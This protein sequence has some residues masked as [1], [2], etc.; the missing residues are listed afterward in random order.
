M[1]ANS[2]QF[3]FLEA[4]LLVSKLRAEVT[5]LAVFVGG[6]WSQWLFSFT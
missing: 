6:G 3:E 4:V 2:D 1:E 5:F